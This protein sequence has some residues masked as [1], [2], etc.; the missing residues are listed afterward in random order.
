MIQI[1][2]F[3]NYIIIYTNFK[4]QE[5]PEKKF[6]EPKLVDNDEDVEISEDD[7]QFFKEHGGFSG[8]LANLDADSL[9]E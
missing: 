2:L 6:K 4:K 7:I 1:I 5:K 9:M 3:I 8:F